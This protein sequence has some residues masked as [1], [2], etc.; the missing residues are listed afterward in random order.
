MIAYRLMKPVNTY[1]VIDLDPAVMAKQ[2]VKSSGLTFSEA[3]RAVMNDI[4]SGDKTLM[5]LSENGFE[6]KHNKSA[7]KQN[8]DVN[9]YGNFL[10]LNKVAHDCLNKAL[11][12]FGEFV[13]LKTDSIELFL[14]NPLTFAREDLTLTEKAYVDG[15]EY[16]L[17]SLTFENDDIDKKLIFKSKLQGGLSIYCN[18]ELMEL[19]NKN[20]LS[21]ITFNKDLV[22]IF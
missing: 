22:S 6:C 13:P 21:G 15:F 19:I 17:K 10:V 7:K 4:P 11:K 14:F 1:D 2:I 12:D 20:S 3:V 8:Y 9:L 18:N 16:G 5:E